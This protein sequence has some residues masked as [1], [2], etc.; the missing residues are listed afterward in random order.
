MLFTLPFIAFMG[1]SIRHLSCL[2]TFVSRRC[3]FPWFQFCLLHQ[4]KAAA[5]VGEDGVD[6]GWDVAVD[7]ACNI[8]ELR[9]S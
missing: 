8:M 4:V 1:W 5:V 9:C 7:W 2:D 6:V 3:G